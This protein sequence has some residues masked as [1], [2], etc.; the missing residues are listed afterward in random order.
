MIIVTGGAG[1]IGSNIVKG[2]ND[3]GITDILIVDNL[4][5]PEKHLNLNSLKYY[6]YVDKQDFIANLDKFKAYRT[7]FHQGACSDTTETDGKYMMRN[8]YEYSKELLL[9]SL[10]NDIDLI[11]ASS[12]SIYGNGDKGFK[13]DPMCEYP[14]NV[15]AFSKF[16]FDNFVRNVRLKRK[17]IDSQILGLRYFNVYGYQENHKGK[18]AS[19]A[20]RMFNQIKNKEEIKLFEGSEGFLRDFIFIEDV[21][22]V[23]LFFYEN[24]KQGIYNCGTGKARSFL[25]IANTV[26][27]LNKSAKLIYT[28]FP[29]QL[30]GKYQ[31]YTQADTTKLRA[32]GFTQNFHT[33]EEG[34][35]KYYHKFE[36]TNGY[37][38]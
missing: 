21:V 23:N 33:L 34:I 20:Y 37:F 19:V 4:S 15:Y 30:K 2:L 12:A 9:F 35:G 3:K 18:M 6:D 13:E 17:N 8:N 25:D 27:S 10:N 38:K 32:A 29:E 1:F 36:S 16:S 31:V 24:G 11:Y 22:K 28:P 5:N 7:I 14:L 26:Q